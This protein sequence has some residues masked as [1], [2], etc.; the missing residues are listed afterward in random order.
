[1]NKITIR[2][3]Q[4]AHTYAP[5]AIGDFPGLS[6]M[7]LSHDHGQYDWGRSEDELDEQGQA[8][9]RRIINDKRLTDAFGIE[10]FV[11]PPLEGLGGYSLKVV[12][13]PMSMY[14]PNCGRIHFSSDLEKYNNGNIPDLKVVKTF[15]KAL[16]PYYCIDPNCQKTG[17]EKTK[18][19]KTKAKQRFIEL[20]PT[21]FVIAN[22][23]GFIE[24]FPWDWY[25]HRKPNK[26]Q[27]R[28]QGH[29]LYLEF[30]SSTASLGSI[31][32]ISKNKNTGHEIAREN[33]GEIFN[34]DLTFISRNDEYLK[35]VNNYMPKPWLGRD[36]D[37]FVKGYVNHVPEPGQIHRNNR[38]EI[39]GQNAE[40]IKRKY[41]RTLQRGANNLYF[42][43]VFKGIRLPE[44]SNSIDQKLINQLTNLKKQFLKNQ[45]DTYNK[46]SNQDWQ[47]DFTHKFR[48]LFSCSNQ[49]LQMALDELFPLNSDKKHALDKKQKLR[50]EEFECFIDTSIQESKEIWYTATH[51]VK[52]TDFLK[53]DVKIEKITLLNKLNELKIFRGFTRIKPLANEEL[54]FETDRQ[55]LEGRFETDRQNLEDRRLVEYNRICD[56]RKSPAETNELPCSEVK[57]EGIFLKFDDDALN[58]WEIKDPVKNRYK[59]MQN[60]LDNYFR[61]FDIVDGQNNISARYVMLHTLSHMIMQQ[62][63]NDS[64]YSLSSLTEIIYCS[65]PHE[66]NNM[67]GI[68]IYTSSSDTEGTLGGLV[69]KGTPNRLSPIISKA[70]EEAKWCS[71]DP[72]CITSN[73][74]GFMSTNMAACYSCVIVPE[75]SCEII[76]KFLDR[77]LVLDFFNIETI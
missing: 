71:S 68:L 32:L 10:N 46:Y 26:R 15:D 18:K 19:K 72:L 11:L 8:A 62:L 63:A 54:I 20:V 64:G 28:N 42:P 16:R 51:N 43:L 73:G 61:T 33:L 21:R 75:T 41:P 14:C 27:Y 47:N 4:I 7:F 23:E 24:D 25:V 59:Q 34:Q 65:K 60:N 48:P 69:E 53:E 1:M 2:Q 35:Y 45:P 3:S 22:Q 49:K 52:L 58:D 31:T 67:N 66:E 37:S 77:K 38:G 13:F 44:D 9:K 70:I 50:K 74:Q 36:G 12:R 40:I 76:N 17:K 30:K 56:A 29:K 39:T 55:N 6:V 57:G 5:G